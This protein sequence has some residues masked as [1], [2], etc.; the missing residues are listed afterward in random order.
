MLASTPTEVNLVPGQ[1]GDN[2]LWKAQIRAW[3]DGKMYTYFWSYSVDYIKESA[4]FKLNAGLLI[5]TT[6]DLP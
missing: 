5:G 3:C 6:S 4:L 1:H 2:S